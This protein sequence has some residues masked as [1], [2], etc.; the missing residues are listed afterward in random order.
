VEGL[1]RV[2]GKLRAPER[3]TAGATPA[4]ADHAAEIILGIVRLETG[5]R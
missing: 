2:K 3:S 4:P 1:S 5:S